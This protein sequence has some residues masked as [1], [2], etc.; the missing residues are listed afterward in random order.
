M[1]TGEEVEIL[2]LFNTL[3]RKLP[4]RRLIG[5]YTEMTRWVTIKGMGLYILFCR[6]VFC[7]RPLTLVV[8]LFDF[9]EVMVQERPAGTSVLDKYRQRAT[10]RKGH[11][12]INVLPS[13]KGSDAHADKGSVGP[14]HK[15]K[16][17]PRD[18]G[19]V[20]TTTRSPDSLPTPSPRRD[21]VEVDSPSPRRT[22]RAADPPEANRVVGPSLSPLALLG[23]TF[24]LRE[25]CAWLSPRRLGRL[26]EAS[27][28]RIC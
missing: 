26:S 27:P 20:A 28:P 12:S 2:S 3:P 18:G 1:E 24:S 21:T 15:S 22:K 4:C 17:K 14:S 5:A 11:R 7:S 13:A 19:N 8:F 23:V 16:K 6:S 10:E 9:A 25:E